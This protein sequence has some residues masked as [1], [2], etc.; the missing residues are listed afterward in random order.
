MTDI[1]NKRVLYSHTE[2]KNIKAIHHIIEKENLSSFCMKNKKHSHNKCNFKLNNK[3][4]I[5]KRSEKLEQGENIYWGQISS[6]F[7]IMV[8]AATSEGL[9]GL[10]FCKNSSI[11]DTLHKL[12]KLWKNELV[13]DTI[14]ITNIAKRVFS[15]SQV[16]PLHLLGTDMQMQIWQ[17]L[18][19]IPY[20]T[21][22]SYSYVANEIR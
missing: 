2:E 12:S 21:I 11:Q 3:F 9:C 17:K 8:I 16:V 14:F 18:L 13:E 5:A 1:P 15:V 20:A 7:G 19:E 6:I 22:K 10:A 4:R